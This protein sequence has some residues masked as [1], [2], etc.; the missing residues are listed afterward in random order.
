M[1]APK[2][3]RAKL[4]CPDSIACPETRAFLERVEAFV[5]EE[6]APAALEWEEKAW[7]PDDIWPRMAKVGLVGIQVPRELGGQGLGTRAY[8]EAIRM[9]ARG[10][11]ALAM[12]VAAANALSIGHLVSWSS[13]E[14]RDKYLPRALT[15]ELEL[16]WALTE[17]DAGSDAR[18]V[19]TRAT[20]DPDKPGYYRLNGE[21][22]FITN[23]GRA[24]LLVVVARTS[25]TEL[26]AFLM[27][28]DQPGFE[29]V[30]RI[31]T[32]GVRASNTVQF[33]LHDALAWHTP[34]TFEQAISFLHRG[35]L[36]IGGMALGLAEEALV[37]MAKYSLEREQF[38][39]KL[40]EM[41]AVQTMIADSATEIEAARGLLRVGIERDEAGQSFV[42]QA[43]MAKLFASE[44][45]QRVTNRAIQ[46]HGGRGM[47]PE[48]FVEK[49][50]RDAKLTEIGEGCSEVQRLIIAKSVLKG[51]V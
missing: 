28:S 7:L 11:A 18:R 27:E 33:E 25:E 19:R 12:N 42:Q 4:F 21:K 5:L 8:V 1:S 43:S 3:I 41:Q 38:G 2:E 30:R 45:A 9:L 13:E 23:G 51:V 36:G 37:R 6:V 10:E 26:S 14:Q 16:A 20:P 15:G 47:M 29:L 32:V 44:T 40:G 39:R 49:L 17:P 50:W 22:M 24:G 48:Y 46:V 31:P 35:R 34:C